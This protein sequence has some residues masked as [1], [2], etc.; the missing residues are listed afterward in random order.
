[1]Q[2]PI[3]L[4]HKGRQLLGM[5]H[6]PQR[7]AKGS[8]VV[9]MNYGM[10][11]DRVDN[12]RLSVLFARHANEAGITVVRFDY[13]G[14]GVSTEEFWETSLSEKTSDTLAVVDFIKGCFP[15]ED[16]NLVML[17]Y[18]DG[19]RIMNKVARVRSEVKAVC[20]WNPIIRSMTG[21]FKAAGKK[22]AIEPIT[23]KLV[24]PLFGLYMGIDY[25]KEA[26][27][28]LL[29]EEVMEL[30]MPKLFVFGSGDVHTLPLQQE[31]DQFS[32]SGNTTIEKIDGA[33]H[34]FSTVEWSAQVIKLTTD[35]VNALFDKKLS[36]GNTS[37]KQRS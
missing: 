35:W 36:Y 26:N 37:A 12:H 10:N 6:V 25:L 17:G 4:Y 3:Q 18:S 22:M 34:L 23:K 27:E 14:C 2:V 13:S 8:P 19:T 32:L 30:N 20:M 11:G 28:D 15:N 21:T 31:L 9:L 29:L 24:F 16:F 33:N 1:M 7:R 5:I